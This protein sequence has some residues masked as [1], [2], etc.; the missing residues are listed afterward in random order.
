MIEVAFVVCRI[1]QSTGN[2]L[3]SEDGYSLLACSDGELLLKASGDKAEEVKP[4][5]R[6]K[7]D[8]QV[9]MDFDPDPE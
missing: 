3:W 5:R 6:L 7:P 2:I 1:E 8:G 9:L 4:Y